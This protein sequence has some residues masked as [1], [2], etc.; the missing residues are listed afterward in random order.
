MHRCSPALQEMLGCGTFGQ[1]VSCWSDDFRRAVAVKV[2]KNQVGAGQ[3]TWFRFRWSL[4]HRHM[5]ESDRSDSLGRAQQ[6]RLRREN[7]PKRSKTVRKLQ[8]S[9]KYTS[10]R[11]RGQPRQS[12][13]TRSTQNKDVHWC[14]VSPESRTNASAATVCMPSLP[15]QLLPHAAAACVPCRSCHLCV[16]VSSDRGHHLRRTSLMSP[17][18][19]VRRLLPFAAHTHP[20]VGGRAVA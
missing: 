19:L 1:V 4:S 16:L 8:S 5:S 20:G 10:V 6:G 9:K 7:G 12:D 14:W 2:I 17:Q 15:L 18:Q 13:N 3:C 11:P